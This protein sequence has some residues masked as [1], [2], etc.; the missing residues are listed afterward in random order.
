LEEGEPNW[1]LWTERTY[2]IFRKTAPHINLANA[3]WW[4]KVLE[5]AQGEDT[6]D[7]LV[8]AIEL[9]DAMARREGPRLMTA[10]EQVREHKD[11]VVSK[12][13]VAIATMVALELTTAPEPTRNALTTEII[14]PLVDNN[15]TS[16]DLAFQA[17]RL[18]AMLAP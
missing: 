1:D 16:E 11:D 3:A 17:L 13:L 4:A 6:P 12:G 9:L 7:D 15:G 2:T 10:I 14:D 5:V 8:R 18:R